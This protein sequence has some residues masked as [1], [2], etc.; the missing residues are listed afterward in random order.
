MKK[1]IPIHRALIG[2]AT[3]AACLAAF[4]P[5]AD[6][7][8]AASLGAQLA[9]RPLTPQ[10]IKTYALTGNLSSGGLTT[11]AINQQVYLEVLISAAV[12]DTDNVTVDW[13]LASKPI[14][15]AAALASSPLGANVPPFNMYDRLA[16]KVAGRSML[17]PDITGQYV[18][19]A[20]VTTATSGSSNLTVTLTAGT[21][22]GANT[23]ALC[24]SGGIAAE[25]TYTPWDASKHAHAFE[26]AIDGKSTDHF[27]KNCISCHSLGFDG[28]T[29]SANGGFDDIAAQTGWIFPSTFTNGNWDAMPAALQN[30]ANIQCENCHGPGSQHAYSLGNT[31]LITVTTAAG[32]CAQCHDSL[33]HHVKATEWLNS[34]HAVAT[35]YPTGESRS[36]CVR[37][38]AAYG[39][40]DYVDGKSAS[41]SRTEYEAITCAACHDPHGDANNPHIIRK[42]SAVDLSDNLTTITNGGLGQL[43]MNC[44]MARVEANSYV[45][46]TSTNSNISSHFG[47]HHGPQTDMLEGVNAITYGKEIP[48][49]GH[50]KAVKDTCVACHLQE[51]SASSPEFGLVGGHTFRNFYDTGTNSY[52]LVELCSN[53]HGDIEDFDLKRADY[54]GD[55]VVEGVQTEVKRLL[56]QVAM[57]LPPVGSTQIAS[58]PNTRAQIQA[59]YNYQ[60]VLE[61]GSFGVHNTAYAVGLLRASI[62]DLSDDIDHDGL[63]DKWEIA[64]FGSINA[65]NGNDDPDGDGARNSLE[66][67]AGTNPLLVDTDGDGVNDLAELQAGSD[68]L[69]PDDKPGFVVKI[70]TAAEV[71]FASEVGKSYQVQRVSDFTG[72]WVNVGSVTNGTGNNISMVTSTRTGGSQGYFR[73]VQVP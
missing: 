65:Y 37:C 14:G 23:C 42:I 54:D 12:P 4:I 25:N 3:S 51:V 8:S 50:S 72:T 34:K 28:N 47:P 27:S 44:H 24:H 64:N 6:A 21:Y 36:S 31:N 22:L 15:S 67:G 11:V 9:P 2:L 16:N 19:N 55:G 13:T 18:V 56:D 30:V 61:D 38:H 60:F 57:L 33:T 1:L 10:E 73:V 68:P 46:G 70:Y 52:S 45:D 40:V 5:C 53:C 7:A 29:N 59:R 41:E 48:S 63:S 43:C 58:V 26:E 66:F 35:S 32:D 39:F 49:S 62:A 69:N 71:E 17:V 20:V